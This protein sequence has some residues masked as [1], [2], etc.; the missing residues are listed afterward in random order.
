MNLEGITAKQLQELERLARE[1][2]LV[3]RQ[4]KLQDEPLAKS[5][6]ELEL[7]AGKVR[8]ER[9]DDSNPQYRGY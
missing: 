2:G 9:F 7:E 1:L 6:H 3:L 5:L 8:R 4:A